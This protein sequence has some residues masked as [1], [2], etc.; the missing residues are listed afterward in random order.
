MKLRFIA[1]VS[2][3]VLT[4]ATALGGGPS[5]RGDD[6]PAETVKVADYFF[7]PPKVKVATGDAVAWKW[8]KTNLDTHNVTLTAGPDG[9][10]RKGFKSDSGS[11]GVKFAP[12]FKQA[13]RYEFVCRFHP[14]QMTMS[15]NVKP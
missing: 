4:P 1:I 8:S 7:S 10:R 15:V 13:G 12:V 5:A 6:A 2:I 3:A 14:T 11:T 9:V